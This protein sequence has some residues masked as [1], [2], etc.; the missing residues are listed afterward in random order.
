[1]ISD[2][3]KQYEIAREVHLMNHGGINKTTAR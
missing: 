3:Q 2:P 1:V